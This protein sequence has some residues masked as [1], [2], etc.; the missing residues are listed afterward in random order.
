MVEKFFSDDVIFLFYFIQFQNNIQFYYLNQNGDED[1]LQPEATDEQY[2]FISSD[3]TSN[4]ATGTDGDVPK[5]SFQL[6]YKYFYKKKRK[7][8]FIL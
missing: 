7:N 2:N 5:F 1:G 4:T 8:L 3:I 6:I